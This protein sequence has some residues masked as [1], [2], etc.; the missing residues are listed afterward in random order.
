MA[1]W[2]KFGEIDY[3]SCFIGIR[4]IFI[5]DFKYVWIGSYYE[6][7]QVSNA[8]SLVW[9]EI[10]LPPVPKKCKDCDYIKRK[11]SEGIV[12]C[13]NCIGNE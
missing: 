7:H 6:F 4:Q 12:Y 3:E 9:K 5:S 2:K 11:D 13:E 10:A 8:D 1:K